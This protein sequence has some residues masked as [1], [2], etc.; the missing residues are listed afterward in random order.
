MGI[1][2]RLVKVA[3]ASV[4]QAFSES[5]YSGGTGPGPFTNYASYIPPFRAPEL[6]KKKASVLTAKGQLNH[7]MRVGAPKSSP[8]PGPSIASVS[9]PMGFGKPLPGAT[10]TP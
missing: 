2:V 10:K 7:T 5:Q 8:P 6:K 9:K 1:D 4:K 3:F